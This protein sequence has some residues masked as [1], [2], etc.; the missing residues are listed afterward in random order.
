MDITVLSPEELTPAQTA[1]WQRLLE[2][3]PENAN[4]FLA[5][6]YTQAV[7]ALRPC[8]RTA[9]I[10]DG[11]ETLGFFPFER[12]HLGAGKPIG[13][14]FNDCQGLIHRPDL[15]LN[16]HDLLAACELATWDFDHLTARQPVLDP[17]TQL[18]AVSPA[19]RLGGGWSGYL[20]HL[21]ARSPAFLRK[22]RAKTRKLQQREGE[23][24]FRYD[25]APEALDTLIRW[26]TA[27]FRAR[28]YR[29][30][31]ARPFTGALLRALLLARTGG[32]TGLLS[33]LYCA[34]RPVACQYSLLSRQVQALWFTAYDPDYASY[35]P[36][37]LLNLSITQAAAARGIRLIDM[38]RGED[39]TKQALKT[40]D[41]TVGQGQLRRGHARA[42]AIRGGSAA[43]RSVVA[44]TA[45]HPRLRSAALR[46]AHAVDTL[47]PN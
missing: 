16:A 33:T 38:G 21:H 31:F 2:G 35:S 43:Y 19:I 42:A 25:D 9:V 46:T 1:L 7:A 32:C 29:D 28:G 23:L 14:G 15:R 11:P 30:H 12:H 3:D 41:L 5:P 44:L 45:N 4:P 24:E 22:T 27:Q 26:K 6:G 47:R 39:P 36:G 18:H 40:T 20:D 10:R 17:G 37:V 13:W 34:G 8:A